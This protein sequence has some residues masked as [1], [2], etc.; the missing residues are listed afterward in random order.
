MRDITTGVKDST[1]CPIYDYVG[2]IAPNYDVDSTHYLI[3]D[4]Y[5]DVGMIIREYDQGWVLKNFPCDIN[6]LS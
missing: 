1:S 3:Y 4:I 5:D 6:L 2:V